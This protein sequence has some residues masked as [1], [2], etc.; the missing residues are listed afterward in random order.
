MTPYYQDDSVTIYHGPASDIWRQIKADALVTDPPYGNGAYVTDIRP[1]DSELS[2][3]VT[4][5]RTAAVFGYPENLVRWC[6]GEHLVPTE[7]VTWWPTNP[8]RGRDGLLQRESEHIAIFGGVPGATRVMV[9]RSPSAKRIARAFAGGGRVGVDH[10]YR[11]AGDVWTE[12]KPGSAFT[13]AIKLHPNEK[14]IGLMRRLVTLCSSPGDIVLDS[15][16]GSGTTLRAAKDLGRKAIGIEIE[17]RYCEIAAK[18]C[19]QEVLD[20]GGVA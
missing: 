13:A 11:R 15:F 16:A 9:E 1:D 6:V 8:M 10:D 19:A 17:E 4:R 14:P 18:R 20:L 12:A 5:F 3:M 2:E 7:W